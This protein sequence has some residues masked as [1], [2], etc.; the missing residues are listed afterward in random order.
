MYNV[1]FKYHGSKT[2]KNTHYPWKI[3]DDKYA[4]DRKLLR[5]DVQYT[6]SDRSREAALSTLLDPRTRMHFESKG[7]SFHGTEGVSL[8]NLVKDFNLEGSVYRYYDENYFR[9]QAAQP[10]I[11]AYRPVQP[12]AQDGLNLPV[13]VGQFHRS[14]RNRR[15][16]V[17]YADIAA[18]VHSIRREVDLGPKRFKDSGRRSRRNNRRTELNPYLTPYRRGMLT[19]DDF[20]SA[21]DRRLAT[22]EAH[23]EHIPLM[24]H[25]NI[26]NRTSSRLQQ[27]L[28]RQRT[29]SA[30]MTA[31]KEAREQATAMSSAKRSILQSP[32]SP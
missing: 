4:L 24:V 17:S 32:G 29:G 10:Q 6:L 9:E 14:I 20:I 16:T 7:S 8:I 26:T 1:A 28:N 22:E 12:F 11:D 3:K 18:E 19:P 13:P 5:E 21:V 23:S 15:S 25:D 30:K 27:M 2:S 31:I